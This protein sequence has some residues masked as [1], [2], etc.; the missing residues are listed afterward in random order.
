M[1]RKQIE[2][3]AKGNQIKLDKPG[4]LERMRPKKEQPSLARGRTKTEKNFPPPYIF[5]SAGAFL[6]HTSYDIKHHSHPKLMRDG[7][8]R[9]RKHHPPP[10]FFLSFG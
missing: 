4:T 6:S 2:P 3:K 7:G 9:E 5:N 10:L 8:S 1:Q